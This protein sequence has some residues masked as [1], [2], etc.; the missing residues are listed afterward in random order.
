MRFRMS[1]LVERSGLSARTIREYIREGFLRSPEGRGPAATYD[2]EQLLRVVTIARMRANRADWQQVSAFLDDSSLAQL[3]AFVKKTDPAPPAPPTA[4]NGAP[5]ASEPPAVEG[6]PVPPGLPP[7]APRATAADVLA[8]EDADADAPFEDG[9]GF[10]MLNVLPGL[11]LM[12]R[13]DASPI[14]KRAAR[15]MVRKYGAR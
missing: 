12:L 8:A 13:S 4:P 3:R 14:V 2:E 5:A 10:V 6:E 1:D 11:A 9:V 15:E 7:R